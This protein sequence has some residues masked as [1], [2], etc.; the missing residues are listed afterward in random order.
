MPEIFYGSKILLLG[1]YNNYNL[2][3]PPF[4][5]YDN[6][7]MTNNDLEQLKYE[8]LNENKH[9]I[10]EQSKIPISFDFFL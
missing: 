5:L 3:N 2:E 8:V 1:V 9:I 4:K 6:L 7:N 10:P